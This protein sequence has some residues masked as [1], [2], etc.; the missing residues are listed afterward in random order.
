MNEIGQAIDATHTGGD[1][2]YTGG[3]DMVM[4]TNQ[5]ALALLI[6][7][8]Y[9]RI[10]ADRLLPAINTAIDAATAG[11]SVVVEAMPS[12]ERHI[13]IVA[14]PQAAVARDMASVQALSKAAMAIA[15][16]T[17]EW[18]A[19][20]I[21][22][23]NFDADAA[24]SA[25]IG[26]IDSDAGPAF[27]NAVEKALAEIVIPASQRAKVRIA[28]EYSAGKYRT[29]VTGLKSGAAI[30]ARR[31]GN[32]QRLPPIP[33]ISRSSPTGKKP[34]QAGMPIPERSGYDRKEGGTQ[35]CEGLPRLYVGDKMPNGQKL[36]VYLDRIHDTYI[37]EES[38]TRVRLP[39]TLTKYGPS[40]NPGKIQAGL[41]WTWLDRQPAARD[42]LGIPADEWLTPVGYPRD[43]YPCVG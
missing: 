22:E 39:L 17:P 29:E 32:E 13:S 33:N 14:I 36:Q 30:A 25:I 15:S 8:E 20:V 10:Q 5:Q 16:M 19:A 7:E 3:N 18:E 9:G 35:I 2:S 28:I 4:Q 21:A 24:I 1:T 27:A 37:T 42:M 11:D 43:A 31:N 23:R 38:A 26:R 12:I 6:S 40:G 34:S 41:L